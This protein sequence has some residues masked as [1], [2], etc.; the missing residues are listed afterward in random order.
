[1]LHAD[2]AHALAS[3]H[4][5]FGVSGVSVSTS[6][7]MPDV[8]AY[9][10]LKGLSTLAG[11]LSVVGYYPLHPYR[12]WGLR[13]LN[14]TTVGNA[15]HPAHL[16]KD[17]V[18]SAGRCGCLPMPDVAVYPLQGQAGDGHKWLL[19]C[20]LTQNPTQGWTCCWRSQGCCWNCCRY[21]CSDLPLPV[22]LGPEITHTHTSLSES[23]WE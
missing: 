15:G 9:P 6:C 4:A 2:K 19:V 1:M 10:R 13:N 11:L 21:C 3:R 23:L 5:T 16:P 8:A 7:T 12:L 17:V 22:L 14:H 20:G 18:V